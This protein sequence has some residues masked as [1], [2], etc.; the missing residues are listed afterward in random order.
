MR[1][2][3]RRKQ[4]AVKTA[5][6]GKRSEAEVSAERAHRAREQVIEPLRRTTERNRFADLIRASLKE[7]HGRGT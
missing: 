5:G 7:G 2:L 4:G 6:D 1:L 3:K